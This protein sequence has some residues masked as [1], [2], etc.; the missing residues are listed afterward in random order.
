MGGERSHHCTILALRMI[1]AKQVEVVCITDV[2]IITLAVYY[3][4]VLRVTNIG[5][6]GAINRESN[7]M[8]VVG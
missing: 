6:T 7:E 1:F 3:N 5:H 2:L 4:Q 8:G